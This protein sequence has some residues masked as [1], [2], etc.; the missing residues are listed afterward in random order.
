MTASPA[1]LKLTVVG[2]ENRTTTFTVED[3]MLVVAR[4]EESG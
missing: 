1:N 3:G 4:P 2:I